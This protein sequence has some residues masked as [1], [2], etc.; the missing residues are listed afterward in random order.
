M[1]IDHWSTIIIK[2]VNSKSAN[3][4]QNEATIKACAVKSSKYDWEEEEDSFEFTSFN[5]ITMV[6]PYQWAEEDEGFC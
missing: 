4:V 1:V 2:E 6:K 3:D 5:N